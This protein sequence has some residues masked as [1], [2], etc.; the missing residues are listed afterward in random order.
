M[1][2][3]PDLFVDRL[4]D[5]AVNISVWCWVPFSV[6]FDMKK[7]LLEQIKRALDANGIEIP[8]PQRVVYLPKE[9]PPAPVPEGKTGGRGT[10]T[11]EPGHDSE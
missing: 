8:F 2:P 4:G 6:W 3:E 9:R 5:S 10:G 7:Q 1:E 11:D